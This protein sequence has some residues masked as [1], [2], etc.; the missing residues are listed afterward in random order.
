MRRFCSRTR[1]RVLRGTTASNGLPQIQR[2]ASLQLWGRR[3][4]NF[5][6]LS[7][8]REDIMSGSTNGTPSQ[9]SL[10]AMCRQSILKAVTLREI[11]RI[12]ELPLPLSLKEYVVLPDIVVDYDMDL[13]GPAPTDGNITFFVKHFHF[14]PNHF[15]REIHVFPTVCAFDNSEVLIKVCHLDKCTMCSRQNVV[16]SAIKDLQCFESIRH[17][18]FQSFYTKIDNNDNLTS[19]VILERT[20]ASFYHMLVYIAADRETNMLPE[21]VIC[22]FFKQIVCILCYLYDV[23]RFIMPVTSRSF[24]FNF[25]GILKLENVF[26]R[27]QRNNVMPSKHNHKEVNIIWSAG[28]V[29]YNMINLLLLVEENHTYLQFDETEDFKRTCHSIKC[30]CFTTNMNT[31]NYS[32]NLNEILSQCLQ[33][34][35]D[36]ISLTELKENTNIYTT[37]YRNEAKVVMWLKKY[38]NNQL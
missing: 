38:Y 34:K 5:I 23:H 26:G 2:E 9:R 31:D 3:N 13:P 14:N 11:H 20:D 36:G 18:N 29:L 12:D 24:T 7:K 22:E 25:N 21:Y 4:R 6:E 17:P 32:H 19:Y 30:D 1:T 37:Q 28:C 10:Q 35:C 15:G 33:I 16:A 27:S 8:V